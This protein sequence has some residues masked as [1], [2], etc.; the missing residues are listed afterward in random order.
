MAYVSSKIPN[1]IN[2]I[3]SQPDDLRLFSQGSE[4]INAFSSVVEGLKK[5]P[6]T[7]YVAKISSSTG[8]D[9][10]FLHTIN[11]D[12][13]ERYVVTITNGAMT[14]HDIDGTAKTVVAPNGLSY[15]ATTNPR[16][17]IVATTVADH[18]FI[19]NKSITAIKSTTQSASRP[20]E[21]LYSVT[22]GVASTEYNIVIDGSTYSTTTTDTSSTYQAEAIVDSLVTAIGSLSGFTIT[23]LGTDI[24]I[25]KATDF[26]IS[27]HDGYGSQASQVIKGGANAFE[28]LPAHAVNNMV[29]EIKGSPDNAFDNY[30]VKYVSDSNTDKGVWEETVQPALYNSF[31]N[32]KMPHVLIRTSD[33]NF[34]MT[35]CDGST[36]T[37][38]SV[39]YTTPSWGSRLVGD[40]VSASDPSFIGKKINDIFF[41]RNRLGFISDENVVMS[42]SGD[43]FEFYPESVTKILATDPIDVNVSHVKVSILRHAIPFNEELL[44]FSDQTQFTIGTGATALTPETVNVSVATEYENNRTAKP[45]SIGRSVFFAFDKGDYSGVREYFI[46][47][48]EVKDSEDISGH[49]PKFIPA[50]LFKFAAATNEGIVVGLSS[51]ETN[52]V[53]IYQFYYA[54]QQKLQSAWHKWTIGTTSNTKI[55]NADFIDTYLYLVIERSDGLYLFKMNVAPAAIDEGASYMSHLDAKLNEATTGVSVSY[56]S[57]TGNTT[58]TIPYTVDNTMQVVTRY[59]SGSGTI[60]GEI[61]TTSSQTGTS[62]V[63]SGDYSSTKMFIGEQYEFAYTFSKQYLRREN[64]V[65]V[66]EGRTQIRNFNVNY[67]DTGYFTV[68]VTPENTST[69]TYTFT[70]AIVGNAQIGAV[71]LNDGTYK[72]AVASENEKL[73]VVLKNNTFLPSQFTS[74]EWEGIFFKRA[75]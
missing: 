62:I 40:E 69:S 32:D 26:T 64:N 65:A 25:S 47:E 43:F 57:G 24:Y 36:Y 5:R 11:R 60:A 59:V 16:S 58:I 28:D 39:D 35:R 44:V 21:A 68:E 55:L 56:S 41:H 46:N 61:L 67:N 74:A 6:P 14:V 73:S 48:A 38:S 34:R 37:I 53:Y 52:A 72:F 45:V 13:S 29:V 20:F 7:E 18:T 10:A 75:S 8:F 19:V 22:Q 1:L 23:D 17:D 54:N 51:D 66:T 31:D 42:R 33:G 49:V 3:S 12:T 2:G 71:N 9:N 4:Q 27:A 30:F 15:L 63:L 50:N 70:G